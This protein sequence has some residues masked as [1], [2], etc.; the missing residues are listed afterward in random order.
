MEIVGGKNEA[1]TVPTFIAIIAPEIR[2]C[3]KI[4]C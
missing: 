1:K 3:Y 2:F 4:K